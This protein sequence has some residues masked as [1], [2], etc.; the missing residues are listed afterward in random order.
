VTDVVSADKLKERFLG[1]FT[2]IGHIDVTS[3]GKHYNIIV[4]SDDFIG[5]PKVARQQL[6]YAV[7]GD[8]ITT[9]QLHAVNM[10]TC[11]CDEWEKQSG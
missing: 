4:V 10:V 5:K 1:K 9:G 11:T 8:Y 6:V 3:D 7:L 2:N